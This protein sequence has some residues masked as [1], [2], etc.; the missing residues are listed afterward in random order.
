MNA[1]PTD[2]IRILLVDDH[3][4]FRESLARLLQSEPGF[5]VVAHCSSLVE[6][7]RILKQHETDIVLLDVDLGSENGTDLLEDLEEMG[8]QGKVLLVTAGVNE[9]EMPRLIRKGIS[10]IFMKHNAP[11]LLIQAIQDAMKGKALFEQ[12]FLKKVLE[13]SEGRSSESRRTGLTARETKILSLI[14]EGM[15]NK[16]IADQ[17]EISESAVKSSLQHLFAKTGVRTRSQLVRVALE[18]YRDEL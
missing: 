1:E 7:K 4:L 13:A 14:F 3:I 16:E 6:A 11:V 12:E 9:R 5:E 15:T 2:N 17:I 18:K 10:G 8:F